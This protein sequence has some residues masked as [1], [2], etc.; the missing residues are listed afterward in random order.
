MPDNENYCLDNLLCF[1][2]HARSTLSAHEVIESCLAFY[3]DVDVEKAKAKV[4]DHL[5]VTPPN[6]RGPK[7]T[8]S[9]LEDILEALNKGDE[10]HVSWPHFVASGSYPLPPN[11]GFFRVADTLHTLSTEVSSLREEM[12]SLKENG[13]KSLDSSLLKEMKDDISFIKSELRKLN[14][15]GQLGSRNCAQKKDAETPAVSENSSLDVIKDDITVLKTSINNLIRQKRTESQNSASKKGPEATANS[16]SA[17]AGS[18]VKASIEQSPS[19]AQVAATPP[20]ETDSGAP[21][22]IVSSKK[23]DAPRKTNAATKPREKD[24]KEQQ[25]Q[26][27]TRTR[28]YRKI[29]GKRESNTFFQGTER[30]QSTEKYAYLYVGGCNRDTTTEHIINYC[31]EILEIEPLD[32]FL[33]ESNFTYYRAFKLK[34]KLADRPL[35]LKPECWP[36]NTFVNK[37]HSRKNISSIS[38]K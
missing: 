29:V 36:V 37:F 26:I 25:W 6:R 1:L 10:D 35:V 23:P 22:T 11:F 7:K 33:L 18:V 4:Y 32:C 9:H 15:Q 38:K 28:T 5:G 20:N 21:L 31:K 8:R 12:K 34:I 13:L 30:I 3:N 19:F 2:F 16:S 27:K 24:A 14:P 17:K